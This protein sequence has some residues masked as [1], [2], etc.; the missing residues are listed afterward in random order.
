MNQ[1]P[2]AVKQAAEIAE[3][4]QALSNRLKALVVDRNW[5]ATHTIVDPLIFASTIF[6]LA[7][8]IGYYTIWKVP[9]VLHASLMSLT[10]LISGIIIIGAMVAASGDFGISSL[11]GY[12]AIFF[13]SIN[14]FGGLIATKRMVE[15]FK[16][17][18]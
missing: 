12:F 6:I 17:K 13:A 15:I 1:L 3:T 5:Q 4:S 7:L 9:P 14:L 10:S 8:F 11:L 18:S 2:M 16:N